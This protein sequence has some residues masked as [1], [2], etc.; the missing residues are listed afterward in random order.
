MTLVACRRQHSCTRSL[1]GRFHASVS[2]NHEWHHG[3]ALIL[4]LLVFPLFLS[5][6]TTYPNP[7]SITACSPYAPRRPNPCLSQRAIRFQDA[8]QILLFTIYPVTLAPWDKLTL[9]QSLSCYKLSQVCICLICLNQSIFRT[10]TAP[11]SHS[12]TTHPSLLSL[13]D[14]PRP[15]QRW[16]G[17]VESLP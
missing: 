6:H 13:L 16:L 10:H 3:S 8:T 12:S 11:L 1:I 2:S 15:Q 4:R 7:L 17:T 9:S 14:C 5:A